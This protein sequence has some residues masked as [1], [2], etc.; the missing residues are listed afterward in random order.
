MKYIKGNILIILLCFG[1]LFVRAQSIIIN[2]TG[3]RNYEGDMIVALYSNPDQFP[4]EPA[5]TVIQ[6]KEA[7]M[8]DTLSIT[9]KNLV[10]GNYAI[11]V[12]DDENGNDAIDKRL[13][14]P[15]EGFCF[16]RFVPQGLKYPIWDNCCF[17]VAHEDVTLTLQLYYFKK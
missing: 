9:F 15:Q 1:F 12:L 6:K 5:L 17:G 14:I 11:S 4:N 13:L 7:V 10:P 16:S 8:S 2:V 3:Y